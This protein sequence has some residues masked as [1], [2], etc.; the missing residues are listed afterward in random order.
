MSQDNY[1]L[2]AR[3]YNHIRDGIL[4]GRYKDGDE[5]K[6]MTIG[7]EL[8]VSRTPVREALRQ[9][10]LEGLLPDELIQK[11]IRHSY[12]LVVKKLPRKTREQ[13]HL[14]RE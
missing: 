7:E 6:E 10:D 13:W 2:S 12:D 9:L 3:V 5:L 11:L 1:S 14:E 4:S 8:G